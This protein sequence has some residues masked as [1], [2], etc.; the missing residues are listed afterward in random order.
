MQ[1]KTRSPGLGTD[2][3]G[4][5]GLRILV[6]WAILCTLW[7]FYGAFQIANGGR[8]LGPTATMAG[9][10]LAMFLALL[11]VFTSSRW[12]TVYKALAVLAAIMAAFTIWNAVVLDPSLW[13]SEFWRWAGIVLNGSGVLGALLALFGASTKTG[14]A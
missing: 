11:F 13:P 3:S 12:P 10:V 5:G 9:G 14:S 1:V 7:N 4:S 2:R 6:V 8:A